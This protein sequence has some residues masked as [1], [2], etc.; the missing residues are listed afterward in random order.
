MIENTAGLVTFVD[1][2]CRCPILVFD[3]IFKRGTM[4]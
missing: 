4:C 3:D 1:S 2:L